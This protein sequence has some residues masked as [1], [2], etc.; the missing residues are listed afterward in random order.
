MAGALTMHGGAWVPS[1]C[2][3][4]FLCSQ[5]GL[6]QPASAAGSPRDHPRD[7]S[8]RDQFPTLQIRLH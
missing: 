4:A 3:H 2:T 5:T 7:D 6:R 1:S 8:G